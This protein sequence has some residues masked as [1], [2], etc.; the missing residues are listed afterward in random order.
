MS[1]AAELRQAVAQRE[2][3]GC[4]GAFHSRLLACGRDWTVE[5]VLCTSGPR[6]RPYQEQHEHVAIAVVVA[7][8]FQYRGG[9]CCELMTPGSLMLGNAGQAF[10]CG[11]E[12][13]TGDRCISFHYSPEYFERLSRGLL[14]RGAKPRF[15]QLRVPPVRALSRLVAKASAGL[16][17]GAHAT[18]WE[19]LSVQ[20]AGDALQFARGESSSRPTEAS[21]L[22]RVT[23]AVRRIEHEQQSP[24]S[25]SLEKLAQDARLSPYHF[26]RTFEQVAG[27]TPHQYVRRLRLRN[28]AA[29]LAAE[30]G[31]VLDIALDSGFGDVSNFNH[32]FRAEFG[33]SPRAFRQQRP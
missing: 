20:V 5:D 31:K 19:E 9:S 18:A 17:G 29:R 26:L 13:G 32:A 11:H 27:V 24:E 30:R 22:A 25:L 2:R 23:R 4:A 6:D 12:H 15:G 8:S 16:I 33:V 14:P 7:G 3:E 21:T 28:A 1:I 10:Q